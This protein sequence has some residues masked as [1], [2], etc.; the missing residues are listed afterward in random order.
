MKWMDVVAHNLANVSTTGFKR[1]AARFNEG[2]DRVM[3][4][5]GGR[6]EKI[7]RF[8]AGAV[9]KSVQTIFEQGSLTVTG[10]RTDFALL[11]DQGMF[12]IQTKDGVRFT[13]NGAF[14]MDASGNLQT[15]TGDAVL[16]RDLNP[17]TIPAPFNFQ[18][19]ED[20]SINM[21]DTKVTELGIF[22]GNFK[23]LGDNQFEGEG[24]R[25]LDRSQVRVRQG[26]IEQSNVEAITEMIAMIKLNRAFEL[27]QKG[28][29]TQDEATQRLI[30]AIQS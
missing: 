2:L 25:L 30:Q 18:L 12:A 19:G 22:A 14:T 8:A 16:D 15:W 23:K 10:G 5:N 1:D 3:Q 4:A 9:Q 28:A 17:I 20:G 11:G 13:R 6:G 24:A 27:A 21:G 26:T 7:G 29:N